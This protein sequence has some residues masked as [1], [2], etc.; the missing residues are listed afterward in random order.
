MCPQEFDGEDTFFVLH[1]IRPVGEGKSGPSKLWFERL[2][3]W[4]GMPFWVGTL[5]FGGGVFLAG[6]LWTI[7]WSG[8]WN[9]FVSSSFVFSVPFFVLVGI[10][11][12]FAA[13]AARRGVE[14]LDDHTLTMRGEKALNLRPLYSVP[15]TFASY[16]V[17]VAIIQ[18]LYILFALPATFTLEQRVIQSLPYI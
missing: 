5:V 6:L 8:T 10:Y 11:T 7:I 13:R 14:R 16:A 3:D 9:W 2:Y 1:R 17:L 12:Q 15:I 4:L 18:P